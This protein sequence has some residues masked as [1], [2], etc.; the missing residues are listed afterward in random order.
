MMVERPATRRTVGVLSRSVRDPSQR[1]RWML[2][3]A[4]LALVL[5]M[6]FGLCAFDRLL[7]SGRILRGVWVGPVALSGLA[8]EDARNT[9]SLQ[10]QRLQKRRVTLRLGQAVLEVGAS[11]IGF[12]VDVGATVEAAFAAGREGGLRARTGWWWARWQRP[13]QVRPVARVDPPRVTALADRIDR[14]VVERRPFGGGLQ[15][16]KGSVLPIAPQAGFVVDRDRL[17]VD[18]AAAFA[19]PG[20]G[21]AEVPL[22]EVEPPLTKTTVAAVAAAS[23]VLVKGPIV[24][25]DPGSKERIEVSAADLAAA[26][27]G[28]VELTPEPQLVPYFRPEVIADRLRSVIK[29]VERTPKD[30]R[31]KVDSRNRLHIVP[32]TPGVRLDP[33]LVADALVLAARAPGRTGVLPLDRAAEPQRRVADLRKLGI[34]GFVSQFTSFYPC[35][36]PRVENIHRIADILDGTII[37]AGQTFSVNA[38]VGPRTAKNGFVP[39]PTIEEGEMVDSLGGGISQF[40][41]TLF[42]AVFHGGYDI[43]ERT[44]HSYYFSRYP[45]GHEATLSY[46]KPDLVFK[47][48][49]NAAMLL[50]CTYGK[51]FVKVQIFGDNGGRRIEAKVSQRSDV[52]APPVE[53]VPNPTIEADDEKVVEAGAFGWTVAVSRVVSFPDGTK[54]EETR[55]VTYNPRVR[56][57]EVHPCRIPEGEKGYTGD[58][59]PVPKDEEAGDEEGPPIPDAIPPDSPLDEGF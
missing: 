1:R 56:R 11:E 48:D 5:W 34:T 42:N 39:A 22:R 36:K 3:L 16:A 49:T 54:K 4:V 17:G 41:T 50:H 44:P 52:K 40:A 58:D 23:Q 8:P 37:P 12:I 26:L 29:R 53:Y 38:A 21:T 24:L 59:C 27:S 31:F 15:V 43:I 51:T 6:P 14:L 55:K 47:N 20:V 28:R 7:L 13:E 18:L 30:A 10:A 19:D 35:C 9:L 25:V 33:S 2:A 32:E 57:V 46:P 45:V